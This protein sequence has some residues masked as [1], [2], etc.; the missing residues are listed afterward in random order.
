MPPMAFR[1]IVSQRGAVL[2]FPLKEG[3]NLV[4]S[5]ADSDITLTHS[6]VSRRHAI[7]WV[8]GDKVQVEDLRSRNGTRIGSQRTEKGP[9][10]VGCSVLFGAVEAFLEEV[11]AGDLEAAVVLDCEAVTPDLAENDSRSGTTVATGLTDAFA[12]RALPDLA[13]RLAS[14]ARPVEMAQRTGEALFSTLPCLEVSVATEGKG[15][16]GILFAAEREEHATDSASEETATGGCY[17]VRVRFPSGRIATAYRPL[18]AA[19]AALVA[20]ADRPRRKEPDGSVRRT[21]PPPPPAPPTVSPRVREIYEAAA[22]VARGDISVLILGE[23]GTGKEVLARY[24]HAASAVSAG[25]F[26]CLN[27]AALPRD[28]L[29]SELFGVEKGVATGVDPRPGKFELA[30]GGTLFLDEI[31]DMALETQSRILRV[32]QSGEVYRLG[33][34]EARRIQIRIIA[35]TNRDIAGMVA[36]GAFRSDLYHRIA[37]WVVK[38]PPL[39]ER[40]EDIPNLAAFFLTREAQRA[41][42][43]VRGISRQALD[44]LMAHGWPGNIRELETEMARAVLFLENGELLDSVRLAATV[45]E[46]S[47]GGSAD[48]SLAKILE[49][50]ER[51]AFQRALSTAGGIAAAAKRLGISRAT[52]YRRMKALGIGR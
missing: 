14:G 4:G 13:G 29:E 22:R 47:A 10:A 20:A 44:A 7:V 38:L 48:G 31:G 18:V 8:D 49:H 12:L 28:L 34:R 50:A 30:D 21:S 40:V 32:L 41:G 6:S 45:L 23:S 27:C 15:S 19:A 33:D 2:R 5:L 39:R 46:S 3:G 37:G 11:P 36:D 51:T 42:I 25:P 43:T 16:A 17:T 1:L 24:L 9:L 52:L 26:L 35:A